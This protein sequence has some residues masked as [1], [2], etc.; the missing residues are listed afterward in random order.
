MIG[1]IAQ[2]V[3]DW[4][5]ETKFFDTFARDLRPAFFSGFLTIGGFLFSA[6]TFIVIHMKKELYD[7]DFYKNLITKRRAVNPKHSHYGTLR[8]LS[9]LILVAVC[10]SLVAALLQISLGLI[11]A[12]WAA[13]VCIISALIAFLFLVLSVVIMAQNL[14]AWF[15]SLEQASATP[16]PAP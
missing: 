7:S 13:L 4:V 11:H 9:G 8:R 6:Q 10:S 1:P 14:K 16:K 5:F 15:N 2:A 12:N 3:Y